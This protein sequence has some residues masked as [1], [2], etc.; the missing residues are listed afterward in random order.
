MS[1]GRHINFSGLALLL[2]F[3]CAAFFFLQENFKVQKDERSKKEKDLFPAGQQLSDLSS[4]RFTMNSDMCGQAAVPIVTIISSGL[5]NKAARS[6]IRGSWG[7]PAVPGTVLVFLLGTPPGSPEGGEQQR[8][9][10]L[11][12]LEHGDLVQGNFLDTYRNL[13]YKN[14][15]GKLWVVSFCSQAEMAVKSDDD[16]YVDL[17]EARTLGQAHMDTREYRSHGRSSG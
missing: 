8:Q 1:Q 17:Y 5:T 14:L 7:R 3:S 16:A 2:C 12:S 15:M 6:A 10:E 4:F 9:L 11:E 13:T